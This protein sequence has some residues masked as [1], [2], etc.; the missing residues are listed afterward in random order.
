LKLKEAAELAL[1]KIPERGPH[2]KRGR[3]QFIGDLAKIFL[4][5]TGKRPGRSVNDQEGGLFL[6]FVNAALRPFGAEQG[7]EA[8][9]KAKLAQMKKRKRP[10]VRKK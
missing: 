7:C 10:R 3:R 6:A 2:P 5:V 8:E 4:R 1:A 9:I